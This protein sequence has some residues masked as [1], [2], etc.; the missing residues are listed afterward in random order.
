MSFCLGP[1]GLYNRDAPRSELYQAVFW[2]LTAGSE[3]FAFYLL[4]IAEPPYFI[5]FQMDPVPHRDSDPGDTPN[6][7]LKLS[8]SFKLSVSELNS[9]AQT[10]ILSSQ[11]SRCTS[12]VGLTF[13]RANSCLQPKF[14]PCNG[15][16]GTPIV[17]GWNPEVFVH[18][19]IPVPH[20]DSDPGDTPN[21]GFNTTA[22][23]K[24]RVSE[25]Y[26]GAQTP[27]LS[28]QASRCTNLDVPVLLA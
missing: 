18:F 10:P 8:W 3:I 26:S 4:G 15:H 9:G 7:V 23:F 13:A 28:S 14:V 27:I 21:I 17:R 6:I 5:S 11:A 24:L 16:L 2:G 22:S 12:F 19:Q 20:R 1:H 25:I